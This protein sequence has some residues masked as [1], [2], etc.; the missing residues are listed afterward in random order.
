[1][2][3]KFSHAILPITIAA[4]ISSNSF[5]GQP[6]NAKQ[7]LPKGAEVVATK[8][9]KVG[10]E[11]Y[12]LVKYLNKDTKESGDLVI[13]ARGNRIKQSSVKKNKRNLL[14]KKLASRLDLKNKF[15]GELIK[16]NI[17]LNIET[18]EDELAED[19]AATSMNANDGHL[20]FT[21]NG[22]IINEKD[23]NANRD[24]RAAR[25]N[26]KRAD[27]KSKKRS[28]GERL[29]KAQG[30]KKGGLL[31]K[32]IEE[33]RSS[34]TLTLTRKQLS[35]LIKN[36][37][38]LIKGVELYQE[39]KDFISAA[40][41][42]TGIDPHAINS[43][44]RSGTGI[45]IFMTES[46]CANSGHITNYTKIA[47]S[48]TD[49]SE[50][51]SAILRAV[52]PNSHVY[53][54][55]GA[56]TPSD[57]DLAGSN[58][59]PAVQVIS[60]SNGSVTSNEYNTIDRDWD[61]IV[62]DD[63]IITFL[64]AGN[65]RGTDVE[66]STPG[67]GLNVLAVGNY[68]D[69]ND[70][71]APSSNFKDPQTKNQKPEISAPGTSITAGG[72]TMTGTSMA[73]PHA[74]AFAANLL[75]S[76]T[77]LQF[78][79][80]STKAV[81]LASSTKAIAGGADKVGVGGI[82]FHNA[83]YNGFSKRWTGGNDA[84]DFFDENDSVPNNGIMEYEMSLNASTADVRVAFTWLNRGDYTYDH[85]ADAHP[86]GMDFD[87]TVYDPN[88]S[89][90]GGSSSWDNPYEIVTFDPAVTGTYVVRIKRYANRDTASK[91]NAGISVRWK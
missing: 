3:N 88:G 89:Y 90:V 69:N 8:T 31:A 80:T 79:P 50:N 43:S 40:M 42:S 83:I 71:I 36:N 22:K 46:G 12:T 32:Q 68:D 64:A 29:I 25:L 11:S 41:L 70:T 66:I 17:A 45:G 2:L 30:W 27:R 23:V 37:A 81:I 47:G 85:R 59:N 74:A 33:G 19:A 9:H 5:A 4:L 57:S 18:T 24:R 20:T 6:D 14:G 7:H 61:N 82:D 52:S 55:G 77:W 35:K 73:A 51:V 38:N 53:C 48:R 63:Q 62:Y 87:I 10:G 86:I 56:V 34:L 26:K 72:Q 39:P 44:T 54:R 58:G 1:M 13:D 28:T 78:Q 16:V 21:K 76:S 49:H 60:R 91:F 15:Q 75:S 67:K 84:F 65:V